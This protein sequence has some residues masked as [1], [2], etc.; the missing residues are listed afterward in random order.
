[1]YFAVIDTETTWRDELMSI[2]VVIADEKDM[3]PVDSRYYIISPECTHSAMYSSA[4]YICHV[5]KLDV[6]KEIMLDCISFLERYRI[7]SIFAYNAG[8]D[9]HHM[10]ELS[11]YDWY[12]I[13]K[14]AAYKQY[15]HKITEEMP[16]CKT[17]RLKSNYGVQAISRMLMENSNFQE[18][19]NGLTDAI[20]ELRIM[21]LLG[22]PIEQYEVAK[23]K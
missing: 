5:S 20:D 17:G 4:L 16:C 12:D 18:K 19:H 6:R 1:M 7:T 8:F 13:L 11:S 22:I 10:P 23:I 3:K 9:C 15:N 21:Y 2:G 14:I